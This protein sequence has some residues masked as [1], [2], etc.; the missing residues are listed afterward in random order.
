[1]LPPL[2]DGKKPEKGKTHYERF[3]KDSKPKKVT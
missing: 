1:M 2:F 3:M